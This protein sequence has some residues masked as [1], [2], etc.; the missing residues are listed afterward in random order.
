MGCGAQART[1]TFKFDN[2]LIHSD[3]KAN[4]TKTD[5]QLNKN[6]PYCV[7]VCRSEKENK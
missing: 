7:I 3:I 1:L 6:L 4:K 2:R 5:L